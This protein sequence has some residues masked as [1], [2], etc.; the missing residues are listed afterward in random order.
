M[1][2]LKLST[3]TNAFTND[4]GIHTFQVN[5][6]ITLRVDKLGME[7][8]VSKQEN[9]LNVIDYFPLKTI[10]KINKTATPERSELIIVFLDKST[11][12]IMART[13]GDGSKNTIEEL[14]LIYKLLKMGI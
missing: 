2:H 4:D 5:P 11:L 7:V 3:T 1:T 8:Q 6:H 9:T 13:K 10:L 14:E 12:S